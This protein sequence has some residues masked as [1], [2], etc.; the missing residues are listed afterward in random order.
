MKDWGTDEGGKEGAC[1]ASDRR[2]E[3]PRELRRVEEKYLPP[4]FLAICKRYEQLI[5]ECQGRV[6]SEGQSGEVSKSSFLCFSRRDWREDC[7]LPS[8]IRPT[9]AALAHG[10]DMAAS[11]SCR[12][13]ASISSPMA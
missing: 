12:D 7:T 2:A 3:T 6:K 5:V 8:P 4:L 11:E 1:V 13:T 9:P 10:T